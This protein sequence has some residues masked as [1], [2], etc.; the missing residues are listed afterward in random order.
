MKGK[1]KQVLAPLEQPFGEFGIRYPAGAPRVTGKPRR[2][3]K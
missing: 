2:N 3:K 1:L